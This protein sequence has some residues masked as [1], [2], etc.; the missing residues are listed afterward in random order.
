M[1]PGMA[2]GPGSQ[3]LAMLVRRSCTSRSSIPRVRTSPSPYLVRLSPEEN[4]AH[5]RT[6][7]GVFDIATTR[8]VFARER[9]RFSPSTG[10]RSRRCGART[11]I[12]PVRDRLSLSVRPGC[13]SVA[14]RA[15]CPFASRRPPCAGGQPP[16]A[17]AKCCVISE[18]E[19]R[20]GGFVPVRS[21]ATN[22]AVDVLI[23]ASAA[24]P[25][26]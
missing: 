26:S 5:L 22:E 3:R 13:R 20:R 14:E 19:R 9:D 12:V 4:A 18:A 24:P 8:I 7:S 21:P 23:E 2:T 10:R 16:A 15:Q 6:M 17:R 11:Q 25:T 1:P